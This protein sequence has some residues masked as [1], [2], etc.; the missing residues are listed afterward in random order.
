MEIAP[1]TFVCKGPF[2]LAP[3]PSSPS[4]NSFPRSLVAALC[5]PTDSPRA[6]LAFREKTEAPHYGEARASS[7][8]P[9]RPW[10]GVEGRKEDSSGDRNAAKSQASTPREP[11]GQDPTAKSPVG[12]WGALLVSFCP[13]PVSW[14][15]EP[16]PGHWPLA[17]S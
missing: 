14:L 10:R 17:V 2:P 3:A 7:L 13:T 6:Q 4:E 16:S 9:L 5:G 12:L 15:S 11:M 1:R 8:R